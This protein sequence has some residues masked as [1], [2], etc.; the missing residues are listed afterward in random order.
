MKIKNKK[1]F[2]LIELMI[3]VAIIGILA[4]VAIPA[5]TTYVARS[6]T[7]ETANMLKNIVEAN[8]GFATR[9]RIDAATGNERPPCFLA[10]TIYPAKSATTNTRQTWDSTAAAAANFSALGIASS[11]PTYF[12]Y[13]IVNTPAANQAVAYQSNG[14]Y[15]DP[16]TAGAGICIAVDSDNTAPPAAGGNVL[17]ALGIGNLGG[18]AGVYSL[19]QRVLAFTN[20]VPSAQGMIANAE[21]E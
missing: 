11:A 13:Q 17:S 19:Y 21:L 2:T 16:T 14:T 15:T 6:K 4:A 8:I 10:A 18:G 12:S 5:F 9:P 20:N 7:A 3:V 1:G